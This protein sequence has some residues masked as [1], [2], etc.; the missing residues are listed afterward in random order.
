V[1]VPDIAYRYIYPKDTSGPTLELY[2]RNAFV[3]DTSASITINLDE[4]PKDKCLIISNATINGVPGATQTIDRL[5]LQG[6]THAG[7]GF[8]VVDVFPVAAAAQQVAENWQGEVWVLGRGDA[9][10]SFRV[11]ATFN[12][13][14]NANSVGLGVTGVLI[15]RANLS[16]F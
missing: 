6:F 14:V 3:T 9:G 4:I 15:P 1:I 7:V 13:G 12:A 10:V 5:Q 11:I 16:V 8:N 2:A